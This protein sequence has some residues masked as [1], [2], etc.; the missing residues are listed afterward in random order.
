MT[1]LPAAG[2]PA[3]GLPATG[4][5]AVTRGATFRCPRCGDAH[6]FARFQKPVDE[7]P[8]CGQDWT[9]Q[10]ADDFPAYV[11]M[12]VTGHL[13]APIMIYLGRDT[14]LSVGAIL[15]ILMP[16]ALIFM[17]ALL[18]PA[19]GAIIAVQ[20]WFGMHGFKK[21]RREDGGATTP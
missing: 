17:I 4:W 9:K 7:C 8:S 12:F 3:S 19:K 21:E 13:L 18:Q 16:L 6:L 11:S 10:R 14:D 5:Q 1:D 20:W 15:A 2:L